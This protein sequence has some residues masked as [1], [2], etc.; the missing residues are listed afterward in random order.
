MPDARV[1][2]ARAKFLPARGEGEGGTY[3]PHTSARCFANASL[4]A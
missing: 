1:K 3:S 4:K 2:L